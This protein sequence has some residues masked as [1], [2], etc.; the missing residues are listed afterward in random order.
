MTGMKR[1]FLFLPKIMPHSEFTADFLKNI[2]FILFG[3]I[4][5][6]KIAE[7]S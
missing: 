3:I 6:P 1:M 7:V 4:L 5:Q 2:S